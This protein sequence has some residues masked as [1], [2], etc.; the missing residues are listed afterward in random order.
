MEPDF[1]REIGSRIS[2][3]LMSQD[4]SQQS[5]A[6]DLNISKQVMHKIIKG[7]KAIN[8]IE[9]GSIA[10]SLGVPVDTLIPSL[11]QMEPPVVAFGFMGEIACEKTKEEFERIRTAIDEM[12]FL[13][14]LLDE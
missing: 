10:R 6:D 14:D 13:K 7:S 1:F 3:I 2:H 12:L 8:A 4:R 9:L 11:S 5:L